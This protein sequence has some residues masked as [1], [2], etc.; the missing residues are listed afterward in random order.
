LSQFVAPSSP[1]EGGKAYLSNRTSENSVKRKFNFAEIG[2]CEVHGSN[3]RPHGSGPERRDQLESR[4][5]PLLDK[6]ARAGSVSSS[7]EKRPRW[8]LLRLRFSAEG[9]C[10]PGSLYAGYYPYWCGA[11][12]ARLTNFLSQFGSVR[13]RPMWAATADAARDGLVVPDLFSRC[14]KK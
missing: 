2:F 7:T 13:L 4:V 5:Q 3:L 1:P 11:L 9:A 10:L 12:R 14:E 6:E 8:A